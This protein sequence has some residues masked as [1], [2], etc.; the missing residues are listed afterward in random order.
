LKGESQYDIVIEKQN[1]IDDDYKISSR[2][3]LTD[4]FLYIRQINLTKKP[5]ETLNLIFDTQFNLKKNIEVNVKSS[6]SNMLALDGKIEL[7][8]KNDFSIK[9]FFISNN[10]NIN[11]KINGSITNRNFLWKNFRKKNR[12]FKKQDRNK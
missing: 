12:S 1:I 5:K 6:N 8:E 9:D 3:D 2:I 10:D 11:L 7:S 4:N